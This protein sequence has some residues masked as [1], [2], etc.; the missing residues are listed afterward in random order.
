MSSEHAG[1]VALGMEFLLDKRGPKRSSCS[2]F[3]DLHIEVHAH[4]EEE[5]ESGSGLVNSETR[6]FSSSDV[7]KTI[8]DGK[9]KFKFTVSTSLLHVIATDTDGVELWHVSAGVT[10]DV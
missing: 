2:E 3:C 7:L 1:F 10:K 9:G 8:S 6:L 5:G 4:S